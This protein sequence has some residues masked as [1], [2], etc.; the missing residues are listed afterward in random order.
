M[1]T[2][3][4]SSLSQRKKLCFN[5]MGINL[6]YQQ[7]GS[8]VSRTVLSTLEAP[9]TTRG[10]KLRAKAFMNSAGN[11]VARRPQPPPVHLLRMSLSLVLSILFSHPDQAVAKGQY[12]FKG[13][14]RPKAAGQR[15]ISREQQSLRNTANKESSQI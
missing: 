6:S 2:T 15:Y 3:H 4:T 8:P 5:A 14:W 9:V 13:P 10:S 11:R 1:D 12:Q 7:S